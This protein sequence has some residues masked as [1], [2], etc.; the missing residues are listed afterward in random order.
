M[1]SNSFYKYSAN[2]ATTQRHYKKGSYGPISIIID[3]KILNKILNLTIYKNNL[4]T[5]TKAVSVL[6][7]FL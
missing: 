1:L 7:Q 5:T 2:T 6:N 4:Y 3:T